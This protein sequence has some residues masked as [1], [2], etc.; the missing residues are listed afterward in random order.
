MPRQRVERKKDAEVSV[1]AHFAQS[2][3]HL[4]RRDGGYE[5]VE[6]VVPAQF[7]AGFEARSPKRRPIDGD[8]ISPGPIRR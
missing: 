6:T 7:T 4:G 8:V 2:F 3:S 1:V 5:L